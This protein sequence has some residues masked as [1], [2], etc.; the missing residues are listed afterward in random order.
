MQN[1][2]KFFKVFRA[3]KYP[4]GEITEADIQEIAQSYS[5]A[6]HEAPL[7]VNHEDTSPAYAVVDAVKCIGKE[8][9]V[10][11]KDILDQAY[12]VNKQ[13]KKPS[14]EVATYDGKKYLRAVS[15]TNFPA[16]KGLDTIKLHEKD[17]AIYFSEDITLN[18]S[19]GVT[20]FNEQIQKLAEK[21]SININDYTV[22]GDIIAKASEVIDALKMQLADMTAKVS[23]LNMN[24]SKYVESG[25]TPEK[26]AELTAAKDALEAEVKKYK[27]MRV[28]DL[29]SFAIATKDIVPAQCER[30]KKLAELDFD[31][32]KKFIEGLPA[33]KLN[34]ELPRKPAS[35]AKELT[36]E[37][38]INNP[39]LAV[40]YSEQE[41]RALKE[42]SKTFSQ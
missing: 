5:P 3:G 2:S 20:M 25:I 10:S 30:L 33:K 7:I 14:I 6:Y 4:Q 24:I 42:Q 8:L 22:E 29:I 15:L 21:L 34:V 13:Y 39:K 23:S 31:E 36:Y 27:S 1:M 12:E 17:S 37:E 35:G 26:Y 16:V 40:Q 9:F 32:T 11:F 19:K 28:D 41:L 18:L 38:V